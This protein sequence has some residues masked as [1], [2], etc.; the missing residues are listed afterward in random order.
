[1]IKKATKKLAL[2]RET[3]AAISEPSLDAIVGGIFSVRPV[4]AT[5][6]TCPECAPID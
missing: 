4:C 3:L 6:R 5:G 1:M 2:H